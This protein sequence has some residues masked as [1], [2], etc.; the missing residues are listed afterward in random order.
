VK[1][2]NNFLHPLELANLID[3]SA[4]SYWTFCDWQQDLWNDF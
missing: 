4:Y 3:A 1:I 2:F